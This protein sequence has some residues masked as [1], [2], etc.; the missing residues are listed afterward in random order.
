MLD[1]EDLARAGPLQ[2]EAFV[3]TADDAHDS[4]TDAAMRVDALLDQLRD[5]GLP[6]VAGEVAH[7][8]PS[9]AD[10]ARRLGF[11]VVLKACG[12]DHKSDRGGVVV[13]LATA[14]AV[15]QA[16]RGLVEGLGH[17]ADRLLVQKQIAGTEVLVGTRREPGMGA[18]VVV[19]AGGV[20]AELLGDTASQLLPLREG[21]ALRLLQKLRTFPTLAGY[22][23]SAPRDLDGLARLVEMVA[24]Y[25]HEHEEIG[26]LDLNPV[27]VC[28]RP[29]GASI[30]DAR[31]VE[32][33]KPP[34]TESPPDVDLDPL[35]SPR[36]VVV[37]GVS[38]DAS[39]TGNRVFRN[40]LRHGFGGRIDPV[41]TRGGEIEG[42]TRYRSLEEVPGKPDLVCVAVPASAV[43]GVVEEAV[44]VGA[45]A[46]I[47][48]GSGFAEAGEDGRGLQERIARTLS[49]AGIAFAGPNDMGIVSP[50]SSLAASLSGG[51]DLPLVAGS[52]ALVSSSGAL[53]SC[54][55]TRLMNDRHGISRWIH[56]GNEAGLDVAS[57]MSWLARDDKTAVVG[58]LMESIADGPRFVSSARELL[59]AGKPV[60]AY[61]MARTP[62]GQSAVATHTGAL[63]GSQ[64]VREAVLESSGVVSVETL[65]ALEDVLVWAALNGIPRGNRLAAVTASGGA[66]TI[67]ADEAGA[68]GL[69]L[70]QLT[71]RMTDLIAAQVPGFATVRNP[72][73]MTA[74]LLSDP[75]KFA[76][77]LDVLADDNVYDV[78]LVQ[79]TTN[80]DPGAVAIAEAVVDCSRRVAIPIIVSRYG[81]PAL[82]PRALAVYDRAGISVLD[83][84]DRA[85][86]VVSALARAGR[87]LRSCREA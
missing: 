56:L 49:S 10:A 65:R 23:G 8:P 5:A 39:K 51:L 25:V 84:P 15:E 24:S 68:G 26:E 17:D 2:P 69:E 87:N 44:S 33:G 67:I 21:D 73:D 63:L 77:V 13:G 38:D 1:D 7:D 9:A 36:H 19:G 83:A 82:A 80:A 42:H 58:L 43:E 27:L 32:I 30:V 79:L 59:D 60:F 54:L 64:G 57:Y 86:Q 46:V 6:V 78:V 29:D 50:P 48:H 52:I 34:E 61:N 41:H 62:D 35:F 28:P 66:C 71:S 45:G 72:V 53:G 31:V 55:A 14:Q 4:R 85:M 74:Q 75:T 3:I 22:R 12:L 47:V 11:P 40:L 20:L 37:V 16:A 18:V 81:A 70:P 76:A